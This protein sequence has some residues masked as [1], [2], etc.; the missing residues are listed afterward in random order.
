MSGI[1]KEY[2][3][4][5]S[6]NNEEDCVPTVS[7]SAKNYVREQGENIGQALQ[8]ELNLNNEKRQEFFDA[9]QSKLEG[10]GVDF[11]EFRK[12]YF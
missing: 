7:D 3:L 12:G 10:M 2:L 8:N 5:W 4:K 9:M 6:S 1:P 11:N